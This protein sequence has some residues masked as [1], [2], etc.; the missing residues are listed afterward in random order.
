M[1]KLNLRMPGILLPALL[2][3]ACQNPYIIHNL[4]RPVYLTGIEVRSDQLAADDPSH[5]LDQVFTK[6]LTFYTV[7][8]PYNA[9]EVSITGFPE[10][11]AELTGER[12]RRF[13]LGEQETVFTFG[14]EKPNRLTTVYTVKVLRGLPEAILAGIELY[15]S[16]G[17]EPAPPHT[18]DIDPQDLNQ[19][20]A[21]NYIAGFVPARG[22]YSIKIPAYAHH[23]AFIVRSYTNEENKITQVTYEFKDHNGDTIGADGR[24]PEAG[25]RKTKTAE[26]YFSAPLPAWYPDPE[27]PWGDWLTFPGGAYDYA[28]NKGTWFGKGTINPGDPNPF[29]PGKK[30]FVEITAWADKLAAKTYVIE[31]QRQEEAPYLEAFEVFEISN[32]AKAGPVPAIPVPG[33]P[34]FPETDGTGTLGTV[35][36]RIGNFAKTNYSYDGALSEDEQINGVYIKAVP[37]RYTAPGAEY[38]FTPYYFDSSGIRYCFQEDG[39]LYQYPNDFLGDPSLDPAVNPYPRRLE[40]TGNP[41]T[42]AMYFPITDTIPPA[43][44][45]FDN[46]VRMEVVVTVKAPPLSSET[47]YRMMIRRKNPEAVL[48]GIEVKPFVLPTPAD[49]SVISNALPSFDPE[50]SAQA[51]APAGSGSTHARIFLNNGGQGTGNRIISVYA[52]GQTFSFY[53]NSSG[54][55]L[56]ENN[57]NYGSIT[58]FADVELNGRNT[59]VQV[60][61]T[62]IPHYSSKEY[63]L[64]ILSETPSD[65]LLPEGP[66]N[67][68]VRAV[69]ASGPNTGLAAVHA[70][71]GDLIELSI[72]ANLGWYI[73]ADKND[74]AYVSGVR[75]THYGNGVFE[76]GSHVWLENEEGADAAKIKKRTYRFIMP[77]QN[78]R[79]EVEYKETIAGS[80]RK[81]YVASEASRSGGYGSGGDGKTGTSWGTASN[82]LQAVIN[83][84]NDSPFD[85][86]WI[87]RGTYTPDPGSWNSQYAGDYTISGAADGKDV[88]FV[89]RTGLRILG[90]FEETHGA[91]EDRFSEPDVAGAADPAAAAAEK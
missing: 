81:A 16:D 52:S 62:D 77:D 75:V 91:P 7:T 65:I 53:K 73:H 12:V 80:N 78:I 90:G 74:D 82:D 60:A 10:E 8:V 2:F 19:Y 31:L 1:K 41:G 28:D 6:E 83:S 69:F 9:E 55:W 66:Q 71:P 20:E 36:K 32:A 38:T 72:S 37:D 70:L 63:V 79:F 46:F 51:T 67:G 30:A 34:Y 40:R 15:I 3:S 48:D 39:T 45:V 43:Q 18:A 49:F 44:A 76:M 68:I 35:S 29:G 4:E 88:A 56:D 89:L 59:M 23:L 25:Y 87:H 26:R 5:P 58:P 24:T 14:V 50:K 85:E 84:W 33:T 86:I 11:G 22:D 27:I 17:K 47:T 21:D 54:N 42:I 61:V 13:S 57:T 64:N